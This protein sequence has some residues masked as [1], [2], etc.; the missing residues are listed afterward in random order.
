MWNICCSLGAKIRNSSL[1]QDTMEC[2][3]QDLL[4]ELLGFN[5]SVALFHYHFPVHEMKFEFD[6]HWSSSPRPVKVCL[7]Q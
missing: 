7:H 1:S 5:N 6:E 2:N 3:K 4:I